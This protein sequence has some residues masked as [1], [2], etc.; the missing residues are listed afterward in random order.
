MCFVDRTLSLIFFTLSSYSDD[1]VKDYF[2]ADWWQPRCCRDEGPT[3]PPVTNCPTH[4]AVPECIWLGTDGPGWD[5]SWNRDEDGTPTRN[6]FCTNYCKQLPAP[7][8]HLSL[9]GNGDWHMTGT[10]CRGCS[11]I[12]SNPLL[13]VEERQP[14]TGL[15]ARLEAMSGHALWGIGID[16]CTN[17]PEPSSDTV[18]TVRQSMN[19]DDVINPGRTCESFCTYFGLNCLN[20]YDDGENRCLYGGS[21]IGCDSI[22]GSGSDGGPTPDHICV[23]AEAPCKDTPFRFH[24]EITNQNGTKIRRL[25]CETIKNHIKMKERLCKIPGV[26]YTCPKT[27]DSCE[28]ACD[29]SPYMLEIKRKN[30]KVK[31]HTCAWVGKRADV[32]CRLHD[33]IAHACRKTCES[34][35]SSVCAVSNGSTNGANTFQKNIFK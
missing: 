8:S 20:G 35:T 28:G 19:G 21:G 15:C 29:D 18:C 4:C 12:A 1:N 11:S 10:D 26:S 14:S 6:G 13:A 34:Y 24:A 2:R 22:L 27:C 16:Q 17:G 33:G 32:R 31:K 3:L 9:C 23:C 5:P 7:H 25:Q 30:G